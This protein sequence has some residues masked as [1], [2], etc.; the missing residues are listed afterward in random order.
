M[1]L[2]SWNKVPSNNCAS[3]GAWLVS[4]PLFVHT[5][6]RLKISLQLHFPYIVSKGNVNLLEDLLI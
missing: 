5:H 6:T 1:Q 3:L 2:P 4:N